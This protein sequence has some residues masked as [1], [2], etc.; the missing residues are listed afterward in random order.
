MLVCC[1]AGL[2]VLPVPINI[3]SILV[4]KLVD[5]L[6]LIKTDQYIK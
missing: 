6:P 1:W 2:N 4:G 5:A 3:C